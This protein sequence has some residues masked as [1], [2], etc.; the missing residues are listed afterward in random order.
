MDINPD[1]IKEFLEEMCGIF[2]KEFIVIGGWAVHAYECKAKSLDG[3]AMVSFAAEGTLR[4]SYIVTKN[5]RMKKSQFLC[6][7]GCD[8]DLYVE[9]QHGLR[10]PF[11]E[12]QAYSRTIG[13]LETACPEHLLI[14][15]LDAYRARKHTPKGAKDREDLMSMLAGIPLKK[16]EIFQKYLENADIA[17]LQEVVEDRTCALGLCGQ[18]ASAAKTLR[19]K[20]AKALATITDDKSRT[21]PNPNENP[22]GDLC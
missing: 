17:A 12:L 21:H 10:I 11:D 16:T 18:N 3:D 1:K 20:A 4:D 9:H 22:P 6:E 15:K 2:G 5:A 8:I 19:Q 13:K 14:L 7:A